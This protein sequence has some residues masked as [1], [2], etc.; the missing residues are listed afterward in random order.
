MSESAVLLEYRGQIA[1]ITLNRPHAYN[2]CNIDIRHG[3]MKVV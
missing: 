2:A 1:I 3:M